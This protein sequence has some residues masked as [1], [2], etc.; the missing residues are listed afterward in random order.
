MPT[1]TT[2]P[3]WN[4]ILAAE[5][6]TSE[7]MRPSRVPSAVIAQGILSDIECEYIVKQ[8]ES[9]S[10]YQFPHC[11]A[12]TIEAPMDD[13]LESLDPMISIVK[14]IN[15]AYFKYEMDDDP[16]AWMQT[17]KAGGDY[18]MHMDGAWGQS[19]KLSAVAM[20]SNMDDYDDGDLYLELWPKYKHYIDKTQGTIV[21][22]QPWVWHGVFPVVRGIRKTLN[23]GFYGPDFR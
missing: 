6:E 3:R 20:L 8:M 5:K 13:K 10:A 12:M 1:L 16:F 7:K 2:L 19:R 17:Y 14:Y 4:D 11:G 22:F 21:V 23:M 15:N 9:Y 18:K